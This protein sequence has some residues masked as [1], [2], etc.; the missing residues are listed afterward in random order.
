MNYIIRHLELLLTTEVEAASSW[1][2]LLRSFRAIKSVPESNYDLELIDEYFNH[3]TG[4]SGKRWYRLNL[5]QQVPDHAGIL[6]STGLNSYLSIE[7]N[8]YLLEALND[9]YSEQ[10]IHFYQ[11][12]HDWFIALPAER[13]LTALSFHE[14]RGRNLLHVLP[15]GKDRVWWHALITEMQ[16]FLSQ[17]NIQT[18]R[19]FKV[20]GVWIENIE[21]PCDLVQTQIK[22]TDASWLQNIQ[23]E[24]SSLSDNRPA[25]YLEHG[26]QYYCDGQYERLNDWL[27]QKQALINESIAE[28]PVVQVSGE[29]QCWSLSSWRR[30][31]YQWFK[32]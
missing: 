32:A 26:Y 6:V 11:Q 9:Y 4:V 31:F 22:E 18:Q 20:N 13:K 12:D 8:Q 19:F 7:Q 1:Q 30:Y 16:M 15:E 28:Y 24:Q 2:R 29:H 5:I 17:Q 10:G 3:L 21:F 14:I 23:S 27:L 25:V